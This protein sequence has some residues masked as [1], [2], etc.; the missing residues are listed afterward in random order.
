MTES[1]GNEHY[2]ALAEFRHQLRRF[3]RRSEEA[4]RAVGLEPQ[5]H[6]LLLALRGLPPQSEPTV[7][8]LAE[9]L[10]IQH[11]STVELIDRLEHRGLVQ[12][13][14]YSQDRRRVYVR[15]TPEGEAALRDLA[16][17]HWQELQMIGPGLLRALQ[18]II[19]AV[20]SPTQEVQRE[21]L[22]RGSE[23]SE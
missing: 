7:R 18:R 17:F 20:P 13:E 14:R 11:H 9:R 5:Q 22:Q 3:L 10:Q 1:L 21:E 6:Q 23:T 4:A 12:R 19:S 16:V 15:L 8:E 2:W